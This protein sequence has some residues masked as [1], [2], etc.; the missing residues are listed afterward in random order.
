VLLFFIICCCGCLF[1]S[2][3]LPLRKGVFKSRKTALLAVALEFT[4][5][6]NFYKNFTPGILRNIAQMLSIA[7]HWLFMGAGLVFCVLGFYATYLLSGRI[8]HVLRPFKRIVTQHWKQIVILSLLFCISLISIIR[9]NYNYVDDLGRVHLGYQITGDFSRYIASF[10]STFLHTNIYLADISPIPQLLSACILAF[11]A[12][13]LYYVFVGDRKI[14]IWGLLALIPIGTFPLFLHC[15]SYKYDAPYMAFSVLVSIAPLVYRNKSFF[16]FALAVF[17]GTILV[18]TTYQAASG[19]LPL[20]TV[21]V[22]LSMWKQ[23]DSI[24]NIFSFLLSAV[25][26]YISGMVLF[27]FFLMNTFNGS[28]GYVNTSI[29]FQS[30]IPNIKEYFTLIGHWFSPMW[31]LLM[32]IIVCSFIYTT[33]QSSKRHKGVTL[34]MSLCAVVLMCVLSFGAYILFDNP[35][36]SPRS[37]YGIGIALTVWCIQISL[38]KKQLIGNT[39][40]ALLGCCFFIFSFTYGNALNMQNKYTHFRMEQV[41]SDINDLELDSSEQKVTIQVIGTAGRPEHLEGIIQEWP[42][43]DELVNIQFSDSSWYWGIYE[44][45]Y[46]YGL[47]DILVTDGNLD[48]TQYDL[49]ILVDNV[50][51]TIR[52][53]STQL[54]IEL[55]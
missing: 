16:K 51:H 8:L 54:L 22:C 7:P 14:D 30:I 23:K 24:K 27:R 3:P 53:N 12:V 25:L 49:P 19:I 18:C 47:D 44:L 6:L 5:L 37:M 32:I 34:L 20:L 28:G 26:G 50:Y 45:L 55:K 21:A 11:A 39:A 36:F 43:L 52:G 2:C 4:F 35:L 10:L 42:L 29:S 41:L 48:L 9:A 33:T 13:T 31:I 38:S 40:I 17:C 46:Y 15:Y 1:V